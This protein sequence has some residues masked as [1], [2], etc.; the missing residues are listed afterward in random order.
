VNFGI[1]F[2][3]SIYLAQS[4]FLLDRS[5]VVI[6]F[7][8]RYFVELIDKQGLKLN[9]IKSIINYSKHFIAFF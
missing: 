1:F 4:A 7:A 9:L 5:W 6:F 3:H 8:P 2:F